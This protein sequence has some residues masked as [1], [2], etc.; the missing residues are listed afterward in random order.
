MKGKRCLKCQL[1]SAP[2]EGGVSTAE[3]DTPE[4]DWPIHEA[5]D[6]STAAS[7]D[8]PLIG[9]DSELDENHNV[10]L[11]FPS[12]MLYDDEDSDEDFDPEEMT[13]MGATQSTA[14]GATLSTTTPKKELRWDDPV[15]AMEEALLSTAE[16]EGDEE[17]ASLNKIRDCFPCPRQKLRKKQFHH[18]SHCIEA[19]LFNAAVARW[20]R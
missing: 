1:T 16:Y 13:A 2:A 7:S 17:D 3:T 10:K 8:E 6:E 12:E 5:T 20:M 4:S 11:I 14:M 15:K 19:P 18:R 9:D